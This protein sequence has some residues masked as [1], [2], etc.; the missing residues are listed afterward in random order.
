[1]DQHFMLRAQQ[2]TVD[3]LKVLLK[4]ANHDTMRCNILNAIVETETDDNV[5]PKYNDELKKISENNLNQLAPSNPEYKVFKKHIAVAL[6]NT[7]YLWKLHGDITKA[8]EYYLKSLAIHEEI[9]NYPGAANSLNNIAS[10]YEAK[11]N[12]QLAIEYY[13]KSLKLAEEKKEQ[14]VV[15]RILSNIGAVYHMQGE[16]QKAL[17]CF[18]RCLKIREQIHDRDG[19]ANSLNNIGAVYEL[20]GDL[21]CKDTKEE[22]IRK[23]Q[24]IA[25]EYFLK[26]LRIRE[27]SGNKHGIAKSLS[28]IASIYRLRGDNK[29]ALDYY[30]KGLKIREEINDKSGIAVALSNIA[31]VYYVEK[32]FQEALKYCLSSIKLSKEL[33]VP[34]NIRESALG[35]CNIYKSTGNYQKALENYELFI[36]MRDS[37]NNESTRKASIKSQLKY[38]YEKQAAAD[39]VAHAKESEIKN[40]QLQKQTAEIKAKKNQQYALFGGLGLVIIFAGFMY[41]RFRVTQKQKVIIEEQK[42]VVEEQKY[43]VEEKQQEVM[44][45][46][47]YAKRIQTAQ[48]PSEKKIARSL[49][50]LMKF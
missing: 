15:A 43:L 29:K 21:S 2:Q 10:I 25:L 13:H 16:F 24:N 28:N 11:G 45:S 27:E 8:L 46:I 1:M 9:R 23:G 5:W 47:R 44:D 14:K 37:L 3:S 42:M 6:N 7:G 4:N 39:S 38:E 18:N 12:I 30:F 36:S 20:K 33:G 17:E 49:N 50:R 48:L 31:F 40:V 41:N 32:N 34:E 26:S 19:I 35:L 22:C